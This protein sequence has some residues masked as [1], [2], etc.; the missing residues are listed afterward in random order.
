MSKHDEGRRA[1]IVGAAGAGAVAG[2]ALVQAAYAKST[3]AKQEKTPAAKSPATAEAPA[4][5][6]SEPFD[7]HGVFFND[8]HAATVAAFAERLMPG[9]PG[10]PGATDANVLNYIDLALAGAYAD[11]QDFYRRGLAQL[12]DYCRKTYRQPFVKLSTSQ[13]DEV[14]LALEQGKASGFAFPTAQSFFNTLRTHTMEGMFADPV[15]G[16][17]KDFVGWKLVGFPG[18]QLFYT[19]ADLA[20]TGVFTRA[21]ITGLQAQAKPLSKKA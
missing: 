3:K 15:Y 17:N 21:P 13:Q 9:E 16:G 20:S 14:I 8:E 12:D 10:K 4:V 1:F 7:G 11:Q 5:H 18:A 6:A 2:T 19:P